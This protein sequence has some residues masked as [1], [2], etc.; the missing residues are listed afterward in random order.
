MLPDVVP[1]VTCLAP[2]WIA[3]QS[4][5]PPPEK[6]GREWNVS[7][8]S[9]SEAGAGVYSPSEGTTVLQYT[10]LTLCQGDS[11]WC[12]WKTRE[13]GQ[14]F[15]VRQD[16]A[17]AISRAP[18]Q[19]PRRALPP[20]AGAATNPGTCQEQP[21]PFPSVTPQGFPPQPSSPL[22]TSLPT[23][24]AESLEQNTCGLFSLM[25]HGFLKPISYKKS[26]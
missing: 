5:K 7:R 2:N 3:A 22:H 24:V 21:L 11:R 8:G 18:P 13:K 26:I 12:T 25:W 20:A 19:C 16:P 4:K 23:Q 15:R 17:P 1:S 6:G 14:M 10:T 9:P